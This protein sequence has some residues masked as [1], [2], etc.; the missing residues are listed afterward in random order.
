MRRGAYACG[1]CHFRKRRHSRGRSHAYTRLRLASGSVARTR[2]LNAPQRRTLSLVFS[3]AAH[4]VGEPPMAAYEKK[5][6]KVSFAVVVGGYD[7]FAI[8]CPNAMR[9]CD[10]RRFKCEDEGAYLAYVTEIRDTQKGRKVRPSL[11]LVVGLN[12]AADCVTARASNECVG[13]RMRADFAIS[14]SVGI[15]AG[16]LTLI[17]ACGSQAVRSP[18]LVHSMH[19]NAERCRLSFHMPHIL[20]ASPR[21]RHTKKDTRRCLSPLW[22]G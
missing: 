7:E 17:L 6:P 14:A 19:H 5:H 4:P 15:A 18:A 22:W 2:A 20:W 21:W 9:G 11:R 13:G 3:Y 10:L 12:R 16:G 8:N 1:F